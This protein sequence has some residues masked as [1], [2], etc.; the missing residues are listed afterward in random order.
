[1]A[2]L[3]LGFYCML[4]GGMTPILAAGFNDVAKS[5]DVTYA[6][7]ALTTGLYMMASVLDP[8]IL[9]D[10]YIIWKE[11]GL[12]IFS[13]L[14]FVATWYGVHRHQTMPTWPQPECSKALRS[15]LLNV[16]LR[17]R[18]RR[19]SSA[20]RE[21]LPDRHLYLTTAWWEEFDTTC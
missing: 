12:L 4:G 1:M 16:Y 14:M 11:T 18:L 19:S 21:S 20:E 9:S 8:S 2:L 13:A 7:V 17:P 6:R 15:V 5:F 10:S 3:S